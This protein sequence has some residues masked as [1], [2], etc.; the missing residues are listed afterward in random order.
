MTIHTKFNSE[1]TAF[2]FFFFYQLQRQRRRMA[3]FIWIFPFTYLITQTTIFYRPLSGMREKT[4]KNFCIVGDMAVIATFLCV[5]ILCVLRYIVVTWL[6]LFLTLAV[7]V[8][9]IMPQFWKHRRVGSNFW[10]A[11]LPL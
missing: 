4:W 5:C 6:Y 11:F 7:S 3:V 8:L 10:W 2:F 9:T 1:N